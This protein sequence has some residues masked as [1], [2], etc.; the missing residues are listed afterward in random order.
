MSGDLVAGGS[1]HGE[2][3]VYGGGCIAGSVD[4]RRSWGGEG[5]GGG[6][7]RVLEVA[8]V[9]ELAVRIWGRGWGGT[10]DVAEIGVAVI[11]TV[12]QVA[13][14]GDLAFEASVIVQSWV[15]AGDAGAGGNTMMMMISQIT[16]RP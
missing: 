10:G 14:A 7:F 2:F 1:S 8:V 9:C 13:V 11:G 5:W 16:L 6:V 15:L 3:T 12:G 4:G